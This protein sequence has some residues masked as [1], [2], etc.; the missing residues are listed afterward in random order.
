MNLTLILPFAA[1]NLVSAVLFIWDKHRARRG[2]R[3]LPEATLLLCCVLGGAAG[4]LLGMVLAHHK[5]RKP[6]FW[7]VCLIS[8]A[9]WGALVAALC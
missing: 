8:L 2:G 4:G 1:L 3:R 6:L 9:F 7:A 5:T